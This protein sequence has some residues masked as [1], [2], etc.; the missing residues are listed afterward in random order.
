MGRRIRWL[1]SLCVLFVGAGAAPAADDYS[2]YVVLPTNQE[3]KNR[4]GWQLEE[5]IEYEKSPFDRTGARILN[6]GVVGLY[7]FA[8]IH[9]AESDPNYIHRHM[10]H[11]ERTLHL[12]VAPDYDGIILVDYE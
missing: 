2:F 4:F 6:A 9:I 1:S 11:I 12:Q 10:A 5:L 7:P 3:I 8:G